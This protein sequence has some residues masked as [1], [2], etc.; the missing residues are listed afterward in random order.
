MRFSVLLAVDNVVKRHGVEGI[1]HS[2]G[3]SDYAPLTAGCLANLP[4][5]NAADF[6]VV[7]LREL[8]DQILPL[9]DE[10]RRQGAKILV[11]LDT[12]DM[13][14]GARMAGVV[15]DG[16]LSEAELT[17]D[18]LGT[19]LASIRSGDLPMPATLGRDML[20]RLGR[21]TCQAPAA[22]DGLTPREHQVM[23]L[24]V[25]GLSNK[26]IARRLGISEH[27]AKRL[28]GKILVR[29]DCPSRT[30]AVA[31]A[32]RSGYPAAS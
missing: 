21:C 12:L 1:F 16:F 26:Q 28:V 11:L 9:L 27:G 18:R 2:P 25:D 30:A 24:M 20:D 8:N 19:A 29:L 23:S 15:A 13:E 10:Y 4:A 22:V 31:L 7:A 3:L 14:N 5:Q 6:V 17:A 32:M